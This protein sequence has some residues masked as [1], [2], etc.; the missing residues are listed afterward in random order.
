MSHAEIEGLPSSL[1]Y[2]YYATNVAY[3]RVLKEKVLN[4]TGRFQFS[5]GDLGGYKGK[6]SLE[7]DMW[8]ALM[9]GAEYCVGDHMHPAGNLDKLGMTLINVNVV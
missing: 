9:N 7:N 8:D 2:D 6:A 4:M 1:G 3:A 5:W